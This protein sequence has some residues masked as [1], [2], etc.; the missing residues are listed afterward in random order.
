MLPIS[1]TLSPVGS[2][3]SGK[4]FIANQAGNLNWELPQHERYGQ[5]AA[6]QF[7]MLPHLIESLGGELRLSP[8]FSARD[9]SQADVVLL[10]HP[11]GPLDETCQ[12][13]KSVV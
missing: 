7:G 9:L 12:D 1:A 11:T 8:D 10:L 5:A 6:G 4:R 3:L 13:R 2:D